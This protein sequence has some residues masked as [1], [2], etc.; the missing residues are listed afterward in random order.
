MA[1]YLYARDGSGPRYYYDDESGNGY[2]LKGEFAFYSSDGFAYR[3]DGA[4]FHELRELYFAP[5]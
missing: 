1:R 5:E 3:A 4:P 2:T